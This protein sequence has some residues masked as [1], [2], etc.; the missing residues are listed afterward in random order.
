MYKNGSPPPPSPASAPSTSATAP[1]ISAADPSISSVAP[2]ASSAAPPSSTSP[3][4]YKRSG[5]LPD[6]SDAFRP[7]W[8]TLV[9]LAG[10]A[11][12]LKRPHDQDK[13][14]GNSGRNVRPR[15]EVDHMQGKARRTDF[16][17]RHDVDASQR[18]RAP[19][20]MDYGRSP[21]GWTGEYWRGPLHFENRPARFTATERGDSRRK[22]RVYNLWGDGDS[23]NAQD[24]PERFMTEEGVRFFFREGFHRADIDQMC[25]SLLFSLF[26]LPSCVLN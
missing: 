15:G 16:Q 4:S 3:F 14:D 18:N 21:D 5:P 6:Q 2:S 11:D 13:P 19:A 24:G 22:Y 12:G 25:V 10:G 17:R 8:G 9:P 23:R 26:P 20:V 1:S 7:G